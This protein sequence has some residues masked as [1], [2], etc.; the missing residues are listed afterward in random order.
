MGG[1]FYNIEWLLDRIVLTL[2]F[3]L[4]CIN[5][6]IVILIIEIIYFNDYKFWY[7]LLLFFFYYF[8]NIKYSVKKK[9]V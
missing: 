8:C 4:V 5:V 6:N 2:L 1:F 3:L 9:Y 7:M